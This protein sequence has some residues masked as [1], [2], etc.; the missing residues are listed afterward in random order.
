MTRARFIRLGIISGL[1]LKETLLSTPGEVFEIFE[2]YLEQNG[3]NKKQE[4]DDEW[5]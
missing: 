2:L 4:K 1:T 3:Y 5:S